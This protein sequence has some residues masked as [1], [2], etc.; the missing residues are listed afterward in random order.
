[1]RRGFFLNVI[2]RCNIRIRIDGLVAKIRQQRNVEFVIRIRAQRGIGGGKINRGLEIENRT[3][4][5]IT[6][7]GRPPPVGLF[8][9]KIFAEEFSSSAGLSAYAL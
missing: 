4:L 6:L 2:K 3:C 9:S 7:L 8:C 5:S 1:M